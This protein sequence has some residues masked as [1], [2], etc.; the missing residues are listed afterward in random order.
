MPLVAGGI[1]VEGVRKRYGARVALDGVSFGVSPGEVVGLLGPNGAGK[2][3]TLS[4][5]ATLLVADEGTVTVDGRRLPGEA[6]AARGALGLVPQSIA[7]YPTLTA[8]EN[9][10]FFARMLGLGGTR[11]GTT[12]AETLALVGLDRR[13]DEPVATLSGG[14]R[15]RL[16]LACGVLHHPRVVL[17]DEPAVG[18]DPQSRERIF[19]AVRQLAAAGAAL[20]YST[21]QMDEAERLCD[22]VV[23]L[24]A[25]RVAAAGTAAE[26]IA[27]AGMHPRLVLRTV[28]ALPSGW[29]DGIGGALGVERA[30]DATVVT[31]RDTAVAAP[32]LA[33]AARAG[34]DVRD[35]GL[36]RPNLGDVFLRL[37]GRALRD[38][39]AE[40][41]V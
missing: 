26:L 39:G 29:L 33:A 27:G 6:A 18:V 8:R 41:E 38:E 1:V 17:L 10:V 23:L 28:P 22:R 11:L 31:L 30:G 24:D 5:V 35:V 4:I 19:D 36:H 20:L 37:T 21:H 13:A 3:T 16:N 12:L 9:L 2:S 7:V 32:V 15:R 34:G 25:G 14:M 40:L